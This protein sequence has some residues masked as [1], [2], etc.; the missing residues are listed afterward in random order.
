MC[1]K[2]F[3]ICKRGWNGDPWTYAMTYVS[4][5]WNIQTS[6]SN[7]YVP[8]HFQ[9]NLISN[10]AFSQNCSHKYIT[11]LQ[12]LISNIAFGF[13]CSYFSFYEEM[14]IG[15]Q[16]DN[17]WVSLTLFGP[18]VKRWGLW[19]LH[20]L[21]LPRSAVFWINHICHPIT[22]I[23]FNTLTQVSPLAGDS[24]SMAG[25]MGMLLLDSA[26]Y[27]LLMWYIEAVWPGQYGVPKP[28]YF[29]LTTNYWL[30]S[31]AAPTFEADM[32]VNQDLYHHLTFCQF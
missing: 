10:C 25:C 31:H 29:F 15:A 27:G 13:G 24:L 6:Q 18:P 7:I 19:E 26:L 9:T 2:V 11:S 21:L 32:Q 1:W 28:P 30:G 22:G 8:L 23:G 14:G 5:P 17:I 20:S 12:C 4:Q 16:W 3:S